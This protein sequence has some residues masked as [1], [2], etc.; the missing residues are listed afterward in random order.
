M[1]NPER[2]FRWSFN[3]FLFLMCMQV[4]MLMFLKAVYYNAEQAF[5]NSNAKVDFRCEDFNDEDSYWPLQPSVVLGQQPCL[6]DYCPDSFWQKDQSEDQD[7]HVVAV[8]KPQA[9]MGR[10]QE[11]LIHVMNVEVQESTKPMTLVLVGQ[12][13]ILWKLNVHSPDALREVIVVAPEYALVDGIPTQTKMTTFTREQIC[14]YPVAWEELQ[15]PNNEFRRLWRALKTYSG[16]DITSFQGKAIARQFHVP[17][18]SPLLK[19]VEPL[20]ALSSQSSQTLS[21][22]IQ[23]KRTGQQIEAESLIYNVD[24]VRHQV[25]IPADTREAFYESGSRR[26]Y[27]ILK[28]QLGWWDMDKNDFHVL[29][30]PLSLP[31]LNWPLSL[32][33]NP[34]RSELYV[35]NDDQG[36]EVYAYNVVTQQWRL[37]AQKIGYSLVS[38]SFDIQSKK[39]FGVRHSQQQISELL[40]IDETGKPDRK[41]PLAQPVDFSKNYWRARLA[42]Q[43]NQVLLEVFNPSQPLGETHLLDL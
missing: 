2:W 4:G 22:G 17:F 5:K 36:G 43:E 32:T 33:F 24:G 27:M 18:R 29:H 40:V 31:R 35:Y 38:L 10:P 41:T 30:T 16:L 26:I 34:L 42:H 20:R 19:K 28:H 3:L 6:D 12:K 15:N 1:E 37:L 39:L 9:P 11:S 8:Q 7:L 25:K 21:Q 23:W 13:P 14:S